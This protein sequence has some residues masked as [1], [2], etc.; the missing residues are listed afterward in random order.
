M[1]E[2]PPDSPDGPIAKLARNG[3]YFEGTYSLLE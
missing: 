2:I 1:L 3:F